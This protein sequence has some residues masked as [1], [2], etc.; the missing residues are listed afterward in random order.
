MRSRLKS[1]VAVVVDGKTVISEASA[2]YPSTIEQ[3]TMAKNGI[4][5]ST[6]DAEFSG[7]L[8]YAERTGTF[9]PPGLVP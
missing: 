8:R 7:I 5:A 4:G 2:T 3:V 1:L 6:A 9:L